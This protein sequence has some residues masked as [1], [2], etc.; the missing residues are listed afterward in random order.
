MSPITMW[1]PAAGSVVEPL[2]RA[3]LH[4]AAFIGA[5]W[6]L[7]RA[8]PGLP[9]WLRS[10]LWW[11]ASLKLVLGLLW[12]SPIDLPLLARPLPAPLAFGEPVSQ[13][14]DATPRRHDVAPQLEVAGQEADLRGRD[15]LWFGLTCAWLFGVAVQGSLMLQQ[16]RRAR[17]ILRRS[18]PLESGTV[19]RLFDALHASLGV[20]YTVRL[21]VSDDVETAQVLGHG[22]PVVVLPR[23]DV[24]RLTQAELEMALAHELLHVRRHDPWLGWLPVVAQRL[25]FFHPLAG[26][27][28]CE[29]V[30]AREAACDDA[31]LRELGASPREYG[32][33]LLHLG[34]TRREIGAVAVGTPSSPKTL[35]RRLRMLQQK[36]NGGRAG[37]AA[38]GIVALVAIAGLAP[39]RVVAVGPARDRADAAR[40]AAVVAVDSGESGHASYGFDDDESIVFIRENSFSFVTGSDKDIRRAQRLFDQDKRPLLLYRSGKDTYVIRDPGV[41]QHVEELFEPQQRLGR[42]Q[43]EIGQKQGALGAKQGVLGEQQRDLGEQQRQLAGEHAKLF[44]EQSHRKR[45]EREERELEEESRALEEE[46]RELGH[47]QGELGELQRELGAQQG[48]LGELQ[49]ELGRQQAELARLSRPQLH[50][51]IRSAIDR[52]VAEKLD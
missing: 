9:A 51:A 39:Y 22:R 41:L 44:R 1:V 42:Q 37:A 35:E 50:A 13:R 10:G 12:T 40:A 21:H 17:R 20:P 4:G 52:G 23:A 30:L 28:L 32:H 15:I 48:Q 11:L 24:E 43:G 33:M 45:S 16:L 14:Q 18:S 2:L 19:S 38:W 47:R 26:L 46:M 6:L 5:V 49:G 36:S 29:Y 3:S 27:A 34:I 7:C 25:F 8:V 31:V